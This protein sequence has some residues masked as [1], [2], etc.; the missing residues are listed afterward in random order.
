MN[1]EIELLAPGGDIESIK[2]AIVAGADAIYCGIHKFNARNRAENI[3]LEN[4]NGILRLAHN[5]DCK[6]FLTLNILI[7]ESEFPD[8]IRLLNKLMNTSI[9]GIIIQDLGL[10]HLLTH[11][12]KSFKIHASTQLTT[13]NE[14]QIK[15]LSQIGVERINLS[16]ELN[17]SEIKSLNKVAH[18]NNLLSEVFVHGSYCISFS[19]VCYMSSVQGGNSG[20]RGRCS[21]PCRDEYL[22]TTNNKK[23]PLNL[24][25]NAAIL[26]L[27][28]LIK[29]GV[30]SIKIEGRI[31]KFHYVFM[32]VKEYRKQLQNIFKNKS[33]INDKRNLF[34]V[35]NRDFSNSFLKGDIHKSMFIDNP[36]DHSAIH[37]A[38]QKGVCTEKE[39]EAA[40]KELF[41]E[42]GKI[43]KDIQELTHQLSIEQSPVQIKV[44]GKVNQPLKVQIK[45]PETEFVLSSKKHLV[46]KGAQS[47]DQKMFLKRFKAIN[48]TEF[49]IES[50][51][52]SKLHQKLFISFK[53]IT[54]LKNEALFRLRGFAEQKAPEIPKLKRE[55][56]EEITPRLTVLISSSSDLKHYDNIDRDIYFQLPG[57]IGN[58]M[59]QL[60]SLFNQN[61]K[62]I[63]WFP[64]I[65]IGQDYADAKT[66]IH[67]LKPQS[68]VTNNTGIAYEAYKLK[69]PWIAGPYLNLT[70]SYGLISLKKNFNCT[71]AFLSNELSKQQIERIKKPKDF[72]LHFQIYHPIL[73][74]TSRQCLS[75]QV[76]GC[77]K[78]R[79]DKDCIEACTKSSSITNLKNQTFLIRKIEGDH[80][81]IYNEHHYL[82]TKIAKDIPNFFSNFLI[83][84]REINTNT[85]VNVDQTKLI[86]L[87]KEHVN[88]QND[89]SRKLHQTVYPTTSEM[90]KTGI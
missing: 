86:K 65:I 69:I 28:D 30:D 79:V 40:E 26:D 57:S 47:L 3:T 76:N 73:L 77:E 35:F 68:I 53:E 15:F 74:M 52:F 5:N 71:G 49:F 20:N 27:K 18:K 39:L 21:Q 45:T 16:R 43:R 12:Y 59:N 46:D 8:L 84:L 83:D 10:L 34:K 24:K 37:L 11:Y 87:F 31:K 42:R 13:H 41:E 36:R 7:L 90:Y 32:V 1:K 19:G 17:L 2:A 82:N 67:Q 38:E 66:F 14:G 78:S 33:L 63:P 51:D 9:D 58:K 70:N 80:H 48:D 44:S 29:A 62:L 56:K 72:E 64:S 25:D 22:R 85:K 61:K 88:G 50:L 4:L 81:Q 23:F 6:V 60:I 89:Q 55:S 54:D 75:Q